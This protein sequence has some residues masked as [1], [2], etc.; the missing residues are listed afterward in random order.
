MGVGWAH[1]GHQSAMV[2]LLQH[3]TREFPEARAFQETWR[4]VW[5][6]T[7]PRGK[8][9]PP[10]VILKKMSCLGPSSGIAPHSDFTETAQV[11]SH[12]L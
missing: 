8:Q 12:A 4:I 3:R 10:T 1:I 6:L 2:S 9:C 5:P 7:G 11:T